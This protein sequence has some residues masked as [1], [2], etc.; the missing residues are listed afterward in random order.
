MHWSTSF[1][2]KCVCVAV[3]KA[4]ESL[5]SIAKGLVTEILLSYGPYE[6]DTKSAYAVRTVYFH[7]NYFHRTRKIHKGLKSVSE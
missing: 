6:K 3:N 5:I 4:S 2:H 1:L 7:R